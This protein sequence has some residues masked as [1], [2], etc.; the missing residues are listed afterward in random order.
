MQSLLANRQVKLAPADEHLATRDLV[1]EPGRIG[2]RGRGDQPGAGRVQDVTQGGDFTMLGGQ[3]PA[4]GERREQ[5]TQQTE[6][7]GADDEGRWLQGSVESL[8][9]TW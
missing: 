6:D 2:A 8:R 1:A 5:R 3:E 4:V 7:A 9:T